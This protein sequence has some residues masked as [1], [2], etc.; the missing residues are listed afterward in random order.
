M[1][2]QDEVLAWQEKIAKL[3]SLLDVFLKTNCVDRSRLAVA[4]STGLHLSRR[5][6]ILSLLCVTPLLKRKLHDF[7]NVGVCLP[8]SV[9]GVLGNLLI[10]AC[11]KTVVPLNYTASVQNVCEAVDQAQIKQVL[12]S[13]RFIKKLTERGFK[14]EQALSSVE[15]IYLEDL[16]KQVSKLKLLWRVPASRLLPHR[17]LRRLF[18]AN[19]KQPAVILFSSGSEGKPKGIVLSHDNLIGNALQAAEALQARTSDV[20]VSSLPTFHVFGLTA[21]FLLPML[22]GIPMV[23]HSD[24][25]DSVAIGHLVHQWKGSILCATSTFLRLYGRSKMLK[26]ELLSSLRL[27]LAGAEKLQPETRRQ[28]EEK[29]GKKIYEGYGASELS[30]VCAVNQPNEG[31]CVHE[32]TGTVGKAIPGCAIRIVDPETNHFLK[33]REAGMIVVAGVNVMQGYLNQPE[34]TEEVLFKADGLQ[35]YRTGDKGQID[36]EGFLT[37]LDRYSRF[38]KLGGEMVSLAAVETQVAQVLKRTDVDIHALAQAD[39][40]K[41]EQVV[42]LFSGDI[43]EHEIRSLIMG[44]AIHNLYKPYRYQAVREIPKLASGKTD[45]SAAKQLL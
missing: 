26:P 15:L 7:P 32:K 14:L 18:K 4:D 31:A 30:P 9:A 44:S 38:A 33:P 2:Q 45:F 37:I 43:T 1:N 19:K 40:R 42:L 6:L 11:G 10:W 28:F 16:K 5:R 25:R 23:C 29:F 36:E 12:T 13:R 3:P 20:M 35:W 17:F 34:K 41:G 22:A 39:E 27:V 21:T 8:S 24:P